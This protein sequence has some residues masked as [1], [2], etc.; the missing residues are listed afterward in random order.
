MSGCRKPARP[1]VAYRHAEAEFESGDLQ[2]ALNDA[3]VGATEFRLQPE[4]AARFTLLS[5][6]VLIWQGQYKESLA[7]L[8]QATPTRDEL[9]VR[10][11]ALQSLA[12]SFLQHFD[13]ADHLC[14]EAEQLAS[15]KAPERLADVYLSRGILNF[16]RGDYAQA[17]A[18]FSRLLPL[19][20]AQNRDF[21]VIAALG[22][23]GAVNVRQR[24]YDKAVDLF[25]GVQ[26][27]GRKRNN[28]LQLSKASG[29][30]AWCYLKLGNYEKALE[31]YTQAESIASQRGLL[32]D[33]R[34]WLESIG[35]VHLLQ[36]DVA[37][38]EQFF[39][40]ALTIARKLEDR[41]AIALLLTDLALVDLEQGS[42]DDAELHNREALQ[43]EGEIHDRVWF[44]LSR[45]TEALIQQ[46]RGNFAGAEEL[47]RKV[48][49]DSGDDV[50]LRWESEAALGEVYAAQKKDSKAE[51]QFRRALA[52]VDAARAALPGEEF[53]LSFLTT[54]SEFYDSYIEFLVEHGRA[55]DAL[56]VAE[57]SRARTLNEGL[58]IKV[59]KASFRPELAA[60]RAHGTLLAYW[61]KPG[62]S[63]LWVVTP[64]QVQVF[65]LPPAEQIRAAVREYN[66]ALLG[67]RDVLETE[68]EVGRQLYAMLVAPAEKQI[69][70]GS[71]VVLVPD[72]VLHS[73]NFET[74]LAPR[75]RLHYWIE[76][77]V[78]TTTPSFQSISSS[79]E[80]KPPSQNLL[81]IG[82]PLAANSDFPPLMQ[83]KQEMQTIQKQFMP[84]QSTVLEG[85][86]A[87]PRAYL[88]SNTGSYSYIHFVT[89]GTASRVE[90]LESS[91]VLSPD[92]DDYKLYAREITSRPLHAELVTI[93]ACYGAGTRAYTGEGL[94]GLSWA[95]L[96]AGAHNVVA[97]LWE[98][99]DAST[100]QLMDGMYRKLLS[101]ATP[102]EALRLAKLEM[103]RS[104]GV[105][106][107]P[108][109][110]GA[111]QCYTGN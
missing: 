108:F 10:K 33:Q 46:A 87:T 63:F 49:Q 61:L 2:R 45:Q 88:S 28:P 56:E 3:N 86:Q 68:N 36:H 99:N 92:G 98:V 74:L 83:A 23:L 96:R 78:L 77:V 30:L 44:N 6:E 111:F 67:P 19:A 101:G 4:W 50:S 81:L 84:L 14:S 72:D 52:T 93:S 40:K 66:K 71:R 90:P 18:Y 69:A 76:D 105:F 97:A 55:R 100:P 47:L 94:V 24:H 110:W 102:A 70:P 73:L 42:L 29:S 75:P 25:T 54:A 89:H 34:G 57:H 11:V 51:A 65:T 104:R 107:R 22:N 13:L 5:A 109:Y 59:S 39:D 37:G 12:H 95:F 17:E 9:V 64:R 58:G 32:K 35:S 26:E 21:L 38:A 20:R 106:R 8:D 48:I 7:S 85:G 43:L 79:D 27:I 103:L 41:S 15:A 60:R 53:R 31:L 1:D 80:H 16:A 82:N 62:R 91:I